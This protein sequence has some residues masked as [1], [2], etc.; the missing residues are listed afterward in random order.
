M[1][2]LQAMTCSILIEVP[3]ALALGPRQLRTAAAGIAA[4]LVTH[5]V[6]WAAWTPAR[7]WLSYAATALLLEGAVVA[8]EAG[9][10]RVTLP[11]SWGRAALISL[12]A[13]AAS[14]GVGALFG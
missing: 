11:V 1:T 7:G 13:N 14:F 9:I 5:P 12:A 8:V 6:L 3:V 2:Q 4:T 10:Y